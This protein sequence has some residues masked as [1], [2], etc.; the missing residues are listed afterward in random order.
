M[1][2]DGVKKNGPGERLSWKQLLAFGIGNMGEPIVGGNLTQFTN[3]L[4]N[5]VLGIPATLIG[6]MVFLPRLWDA[7]SDPLCGQWS[8]NCRS[9]W[10]RRRPFLFVGAIG[11]AISF[12]LF[13]N[14]PFAVGNTKALAVW[15]LALG[16]AVY[17]FWT[18]F[19]IP[20]GALAYELS[21]DYD[22]RTRIMGVRM[23]MAQI[24]EAIRG[25]MLPFG[26]LLISTTSFAGSPRH[27]FAAA[28][29][30]YALIILVSGLITAA[31]VKERFGGSAAVGMS[32]W[33]SMG[34]TLRD[35]LYLRLVCF[36]ILFTFGFF[37]LATT[38]VYRI[39]FHMNDPVLFGHQCVANAISVLVSIFLWNK[40]TPHIGKVWAL[41]IGVLFCVAAAAITYVAYV[42]GCRWRAFLVSL[43]WGPG[44][45]A[46]TVMVPAIIADLTDL[47]E[48]KTGKRREGSYASVAGFIAKLALT[49]VGVLVGVV[50]DYVVQ[51]DPSLGVSQ[52]PE[53][54]QRM[55]VWTV[56]IP[57]I[58]FG[59]ALL[60]L[61]RFSL[62]KQRMHEVHALLDARRR[63]TTGV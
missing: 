20:Y 49:G 48:L 42:P 63:S 44:W 37:F 35:R 46:Y 39:T 34:T 28:G 15:L 17:T 31:A 13:W 10:G 33:Q 41:R 27:A 18:V 38:I 59:L 62:T 56:I 57:L 40:I 21:L 22:E 53:T 8:D 50:L 1:V 61:A 24:A 23:A 11:L 9:R 52:T 26:L 32:I 16:L 36:Q 43:L 5:A 12:C 60:L 58:F 30:A 14:P 51:F 54:W 45:A 3:P 25:Y 47:D 19:F 29:F 4:Y 6:V 7:V 2:E 55:R